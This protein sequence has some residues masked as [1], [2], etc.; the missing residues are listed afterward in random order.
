METCV[1]CDIVQSVGD[2]SAIVHGLLLRWPV[3]AGIKRFEEQFG[4]NSYFDG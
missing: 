1:S 4:A 3:L 2:R